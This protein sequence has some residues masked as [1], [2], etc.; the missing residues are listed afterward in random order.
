MASC[1]ETYYE[2]YNEDGRLTVRHG[3]V[4]YLTTMRYI[5]RYLPEGSKILEVG[6]GTGR[7]SIA[8]AREGYSVSAVELVP[9][10][11]EIFRS[12]LTEE[13]T[14]TVLQGS[15]LD[16]SCFA[17]DTFDGVLVLGP[18]YHLFTEEDKLLALAEA[19]RVMKKD[20]ILFVAY[21]M[22]DPS[23][24]T[25]CFSGDGHLL[26]EQLGK[27]RLTEDF[28]FKSVPEEIFEVHRTEDINRLNEKSGLVRQEL[29]GTDL[30][31]KYI[32]DRIDTWEEEIWEY[33]LKYHFTICMR[34]DM[35]GLS[36]HVLDILKKKADQNPK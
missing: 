1:I 32:E 10:N 18:L 16:L 11:V 21:C 24:F 13:D 3:Q 23:M 27:E 35:I 19:K 36:H 34:Q 28:R 14:V 25:Y 22:N 5:H 33:Y 4:E 6:A 30:F 9:H 7:Y 12:K 2:N 26:K 17:D 20:G 15:A 31:T 29:I 8:L